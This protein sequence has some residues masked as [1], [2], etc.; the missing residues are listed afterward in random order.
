MAK[1]DKKLNHTTNLPHWQP[2]TDL[3][4]CPLQNIILKK[5]GQGRF[6]KDVDR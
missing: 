3:A 1:Q 4:I 2:C 6:W 5:A